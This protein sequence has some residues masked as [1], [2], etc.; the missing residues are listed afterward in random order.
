MRGSGQGH[1][2]VAQGLRESALLYP[3]QGLR[4]SAQAHLQRFYEAHGF[5]AEGA[6]YLE[7]DIPHI[8][9]SRA[10]PSL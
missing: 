2:L 6:P 7:D 5:C 9:M 4:I 1:A 3:G 8:E 10:A